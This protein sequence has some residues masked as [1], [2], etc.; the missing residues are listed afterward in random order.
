MIILV[1]DQPNIPFGQMRPLRDAIY[2]FIDRLTPSDRVAVV[3]L[4]QPSVS[5]PFI[6]DKAQLKEALDRI[7]G[8]RQQNAG[9]GAHEIGLSAAV[10]ID[11]GDEATLMQVAARDCPGRTQ[12]ERQPCIDEIRGEAQSIASETRQSGDFTLNSLREVL[13]SIKAVEGP[14]TV[15]F[16]SQG[17]FSDRE[18]GDDTGRINELG[19]LASAA[20]ARI[21]SLRMEESSVDI[22]R[23]KATQPQLNLED[24][25]MASKRT[26]ATAT[27][28]RTRSG[29]T[30][31][32]PAS[33]S[34]CSARWSP[35]GR[36]QRRPRDRRNRWLL[37]R[38]ARPF[39]PRACRSARSHFP[40]A[41]WTRENSGCL[42]T[43]KSAALTRRRSVSRSRITCSTRTARRSTAR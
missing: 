41:A 4:G 2:S 11:R 36:I 43:R 34:A 32:A 8:Q 16:V 1:V 6:A 12:R 17:F 30:S 40:S 10:A 3:G 24:Q 38:S 19:S 37:L 25:L 33:R 7:P 14:K 31:A 15:L 21:Y 29:S 23:Q 5:T 39:R 26:R 20:R 28:N 18:R 42:F 22:T 35:A 27:A 9:G 13:T